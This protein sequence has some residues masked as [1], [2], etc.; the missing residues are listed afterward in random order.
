[1]DIDKFRA[2]HKGKCVCCD[3][4]KPLDSLIKQTSKG[5]ECVDCLVEQEATTFAYGMGK[6]L[7]IDSANNTIEIKEP[8]KIIGWCLG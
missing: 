7:H 6:P 3:T 1:M 2:D 5:Y 4:P 8:T